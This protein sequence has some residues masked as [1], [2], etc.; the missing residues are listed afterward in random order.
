V[1]LHASSYVS[2]YVSETGLATVELIN[3]LTDPDALMDDEAAEQGAKSLVL[4][5]SP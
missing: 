4:I 3:E 2:S 1:S 5:P